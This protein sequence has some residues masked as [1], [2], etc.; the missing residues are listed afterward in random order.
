[1]ADDRRPTSDLSTTDGPQQQRDDAEPPPLSSIRIKGG[2]GRGLNRRAI[3][4]TAGGAAILVLVPATGVLAPSQSGNPAETKPMMSAPARPEMAKGAIRDLPT[5]Y[6]EA[7]KR[8]ASPEPAPQPPQ[9]GPPLPGDVA[10]FAPYPSDYG[11]APLLNH[12]EALPSEPTELDAGEKEA[13][14]A[15]RADL[16]FA[17]RQTP[18]SPQPASQLPPHQRDQTPLTIGKTAPE[19]QPAPPSTRSPSLHPGTIIPASLI[20]GIN[21]ESPGPVIAQVTQSIYDSDTGRLLLIPQ[22]ARLIGDYRSASKY[23]QSRLAITWSR[24]LMPDGQEIALDEAAIDPSGAAGARGDVDAHWGDVLGAAFLGTM[25]NVGVATTEDPQLTY[26]AI[27]VVRDPV[28]QAVTDG[29]QRTASNVAGR[30]VD[31]SL[32]IPP[33]IRIEAGTRIAVMVSRRRDF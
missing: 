7:Q 16:F 20:T 21:S 28:D 5:T 15:D 6:I 26:G 13:I 19:D 33:T 11:E 2:H 32:A 23:G 25:I 12:R 9:L 22:G 3:V 31:R 14:Q 1:M 4:M 17:L 27:G 24:L 29:V 30:T 8:A 18:V 10:A